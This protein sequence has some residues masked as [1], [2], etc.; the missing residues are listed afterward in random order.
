MAL[1]QASRNS[2]PMT[3]HLA[4]AETTTT[5]QRVSLM[6]R[7]VEYVKDHQG[8]TAGEIAH[9][10]D[11]ER[12]EVSKRLADARALGLVENREPR[13]C[14]VKKSTMMTWYSRD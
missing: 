5:G 9:A 7:A 3:S 14:M 11:M 10:L 8:F 6:M 12:S 1:P 4:E 2:D 13:R